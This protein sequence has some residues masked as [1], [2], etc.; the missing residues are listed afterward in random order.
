MKDPAYAI[1]I[2]QHDAALG[3]KLDTKGATFEESKAE[4]KKILLEK[5]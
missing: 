3:R 1:K 2:Q 4:I 5:V